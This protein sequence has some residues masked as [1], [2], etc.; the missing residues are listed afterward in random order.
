MAVERDR[1]RGVPAAF[2]I[3]VRIRPVGGESTDPLDVTCEIQLEDPSTGAAQDIGR[4][5]RDELIALEQAARH[6]N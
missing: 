4:E 2:V 5:I 3:S 6:Y 1:D